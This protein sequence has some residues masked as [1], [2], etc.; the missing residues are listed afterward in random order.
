MKRLL[1]LLFL[2]SCS[3]LTAQVKSNVVLFTSNGEKFTAIVNGLRMNESPATNV[4]INELA[5]EFF[6]LKVIF[7]DSSLGEREFNLNLS[8]QQGKETTC[9]IR[10]NKKGKYVLR[11]MG[12]VAITQATPD[13]EP[14]Q[15]PP[16]GTNSPEPAQ[17]AETVTQTVT[18]TTTT[19][20]QPDGVNVN[21]GVSMNE[22]GGNINMNVSGLESGSTTTQ[23]T[24]SVTQTKTTSTTTS[25]NAPAIEPVPEPAPVYLPGYSG[26]VGCPS[27]V[28]PKEFND[29]KRSINRKTFED[30][31]MTIA[32]Q[33]VGNACLFSSQVRELMLLFTFE[34][35]RLD[36]ARFAYTRTYDTGNY[37]K[38]NDAFS[39]ESSI[40]ELNDYIES[41]R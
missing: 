3:Q 14:V 27:P 12:S 9:N 18:T 5:G 11:Y 4:R 26:P 37:Y 10:K 15:H 28:S 31:K 7:D 36:L 25:A 32:R 38:V 22:Q 20:G 13:P 29:L 8:M 30:S 39:F 17:T 34:E 24:T 33:V 2:L 41:R 1:T 21:M 40:A 16:A 35:S 6:K 23:S 19:G